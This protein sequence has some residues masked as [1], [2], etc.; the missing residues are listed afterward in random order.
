MSSNLIVYF[1]SALL[2]FGMPAL[3]IVLIS[4]FRLREREL[5]LKLGAEQRTAPSTEER[6][7]RVEEA[8]ARLDRAVHGE[9]ALPD[10]LE[11]PAE[12]QRSTPAWTKAR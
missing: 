10:I 1:V 6:L 7:Q 3:A 11:A 5:I 8:V 4:Y 9:A 12:G 2:V